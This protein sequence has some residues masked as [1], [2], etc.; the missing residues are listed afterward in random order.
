MN[1]DQPIPITQPSNVGRIRQE[2]TEKIL[3][4][5]AHEFV[6]HGFRGASLQNIAERAGL[7]K[8]NVLYYFKS[9]QGLYLALLENILTLWNSAFDHI[10]VEDDPAEALSSYI[11]AKVRYSFTHP[12]ASRIFASEIIHGAPNLTEQLGQPLK[13][14]VA[15]R[16]TVIEQWIAQGKMLPV[17]PLHLMFLIWGSTQ[18]YADFGAQVEQLVPQPLDA[19]EQ[20]RVA[21]QLTDIVLRGCGLM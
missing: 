11:H 17:D 4:A 7:P 18:F 16:T 14:W 1:V 3:A 19:D 9:K 21:D 15:G 10:S 6:N 5:A 8:A 13:D 20:Q 2:N 12:M